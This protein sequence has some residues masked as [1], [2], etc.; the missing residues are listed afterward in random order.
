MHATIADVIADTAQNSIE[1]G[2]RRVSVELVEDG[3]T[4]A[5][6]V[7]D[8]GKGMDAAWREKAFDPFVTEAGKHG[9]RKVGLG[10]PFLKQ[11]CETCD[12]ACSLASKPGVGTTLSFRLN[13][14]HIDLPPTGDV[15][16]LATALFSGPSGFELVFTHRKGGAAYSVARSELADAVG[17]LE[18][19]GGLSRAL[20]FLRAQE[21]ALCRRS[22]PSAQGASLA[23]EGRG[24]YWI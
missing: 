9:R 7:A 8:N 12:G 24:P 1:A 16:E 6:T 3:A 20:A 23:R 11:L 4:I 22:V 2:A 19:A 21:D 15:A 13:A 17:G 10:L 14:T 5:V 18:T